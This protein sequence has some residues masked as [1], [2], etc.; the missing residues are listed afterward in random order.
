[1]TRII[2]FVFIMAVSLIAVAL[3]VV[4]VLVASHKA[5]KAKREGVA[6]DDDDERWITCRYCGT[7][8]RNSEAK[9]GNCGASR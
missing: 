1:M 7:K 6:E 5:K 8:R 9:C 4:G 2:S 3:A